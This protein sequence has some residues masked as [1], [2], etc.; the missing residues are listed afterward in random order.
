MTKQFCRVGYSNTNLNALKDIEA[1][2]NT[3]NYFKELIYKSEDSKKKN[4]TL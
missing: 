2:K 3:Y 1:L 4:A